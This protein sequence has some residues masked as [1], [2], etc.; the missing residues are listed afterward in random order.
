MFF[1]GYHFAF[2]KYNNVRLL[3]PYEYGSLMHY[4]AYSSFA[5][6]QRQPVM[7]PR[8][9]GAIIGNRKNLTGLDIAKIQIL[10]GCRRVVSK[11]SC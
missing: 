4:G 9:S 5:I 7:I 11:S 2:A 10:Y 3:T 1:L 6:N 8:Q